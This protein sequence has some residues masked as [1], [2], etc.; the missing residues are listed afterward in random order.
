MNNCFGSL[1]TLTSA[2]LEVGARVVNLV[3]Y[4]YLKHPTEIN[5]YPI[6]KKKTDI[7]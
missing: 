1:A 5:G 7:K 6:C 2:I 3:I 4:V